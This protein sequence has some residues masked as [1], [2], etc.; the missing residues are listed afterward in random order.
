MGESFHD[1][2]GP[3]E[4]AEE[5]RKSYQDVETESA[6]QLFADAHQ[7]AGSSGGAC[8]PQL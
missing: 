3:M 2:A 4:Q 7:R 5:E 6:K 1:A 8:H